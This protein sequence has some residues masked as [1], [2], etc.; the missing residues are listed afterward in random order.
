MQDGSWK[1]LTL[2]A[3]AEGNKS[4]SVYDDGAYHQEKY[5]KVMKPQAFRLI[6]VVYPA[7]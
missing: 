6:G 5:P 1:M 4:D 3:R 7:L 2:R